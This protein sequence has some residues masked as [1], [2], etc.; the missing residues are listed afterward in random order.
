MSSFSYKD[1]VHDL[2]VWNII[3]VDYVVETKQYADELVYCLM[4][5]KRNRRIKDLTDE[6]PANATNFYRYLITCNLEGESTNG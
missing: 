3:I 5:V 4:H 6:L 2:T 1:Y